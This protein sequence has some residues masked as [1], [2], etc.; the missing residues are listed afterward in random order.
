M[1]PSIAA[2]RLLMRRAMVARNFA[3]AILAVAAAACGHPAAQSDGADDP[4]IVDDAG[5]DDV[6]LGADAD[7]GAPPDLADAGPSLD[8]LRARCTFGPG[9]KVADTLGI[10]AEARKALPIDHIVVIMQENRSFDHY[11][12]RLTQ[13]G[14]A[15]DGIPAKYTNP[16][17][18]GATVAPAHGTT[19]CISP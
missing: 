8:E 17:G 3:F 16:D 11:L 1:H 5:A 19:T 9:A 12:G 15:V 18:N 10:S 6:D 7:A 14:H 13:F 4:G 2:R